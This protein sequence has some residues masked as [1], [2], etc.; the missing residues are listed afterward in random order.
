[1]ARIRTIKP[2]FWRNEQLSEISAEAALMAVGLLNHCDD[3]GY[4]N[5]NP[6]ILKADIFPLRNLSM[7]P[8]ELLSELSVIGFVEL[9]YD[10]EN[11][12]KSRIYGKV[13]KFTEHQRIN[14][15]TP[16]KIKSLSLVSDNSLS[17]HGA[18]TVG[19][20]KG[21]GKGKEQ[22]TGN[23]EQGT[24]K[25][26]VAKPQKTPL[27]EN[28]FISDDVRLWFAEKKYTENINDH[29]EA[30]I[31]KCKQHGYRYSDWDSAF[32]NAIR[33]DWAKL[34]RVNGTKQRPMT[35]EE[36]RQENTAK[37]KEAFL[38]SFKTIEG[39]VVK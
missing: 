11:N 6:S 9:Y 19:K 34:R 21:K 23:R 25:G 33:D 12:C 10:E 14:R 3:E 4:F 26:S 31:E 37:A 18:L 27:P 22:G 35:F 7:T 28:F 16:S 13:V 8:H 5:A 2:E 1:M 29:L 32:K 15:P 20:G 36:I 38:A 39:E 30:F 24:G 17:T